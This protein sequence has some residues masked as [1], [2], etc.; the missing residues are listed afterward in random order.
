MREGGGGQCSKG[1]VGVVSFPHL[2][3]MLQHAPLVN[4]ECSSLAGSR[5]AGTAWAGKEGVSHG[6]Q[7]MQCREHACSAGRWPRVG[8]GGRGAGGHLT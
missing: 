4:G 7:L 2:H 3:G 8:G 1:G 5:L 6:R